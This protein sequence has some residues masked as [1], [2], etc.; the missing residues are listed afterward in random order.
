M[1]NSPWKGDKDIEKPNFEQ[2]FRENVREQIIISRIFEQ[3][4]EQRNRRKEEMQ[5]IVI[6]HKDP[7]YYSCNSTVME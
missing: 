6:C 4:L 3:N 2:I 7:L 5:T 1:R